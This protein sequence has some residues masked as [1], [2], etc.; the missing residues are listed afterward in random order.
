[1]LWQCAASLALLQGVPA[2]IAAELAEAHAD[3]PIPSLTRQVDCPPRR[4]ERPP[5]MLKTAALVNNSLRAGRGQS[6]SYC[7]PCLRIVI[8]A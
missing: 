8:A 3:L 6:R 1:M 2:V 5:P 7:S 4:E